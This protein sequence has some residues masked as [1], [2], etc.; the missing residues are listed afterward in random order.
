MSSTY[1]GVIQGLNPVYYWRLNKTI[2]SYVLPVYTM[3]YCN[4]PEERR[5]YTNVES[6]GSSADHSAGWYF[7][8]GMPTPNPYGNFGPIAGGDSNGLLVFDTYDNPGPRLLKTGSSVSMTH[9]IPMG[10]NKDSTINMWFKTIPAIPTGVTTNQHIMT[11]S[12]NT[13]LEQ[14]FMIAERQKDVGGVDSNEI[15]IKT[16][17]YDTSQAINWSG[18]E[19]GYNHF[20]T[21]EWN[22]LT[23][24]SAAVLEDGTLV[25]G[26]KIYI[27]GKILFSIDSVWEDML[28]SPGVNLAY[29]Y[30]MCGYST[31][32]PVKPGACAEVSMFDRVLNDSQISEI[33]YHAT[34][35]SPARVRGGLNRQLGRLV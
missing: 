21:T 25:D 8:A 16:K 1:P 20:V 24:T 10:R 26:Q 17:A 15:K 2:N 13:N 30:L 9:E 5:K 33:Y 31:A 14:H 28:D 22:M 27:N 6:S 7:N 29:M 11:S 19:V 12:R 3:F 23:Y 35:P 4:L 18:A 34:S 32:T